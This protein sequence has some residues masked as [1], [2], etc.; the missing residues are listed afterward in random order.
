[1]IIMI[2]YSLVI[3]LNHLELDLNLFN[4]EF[5]IFYLYLSRSLGLA[6]IYF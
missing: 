4:I 6:Y 2:E 5:L 1:M 3:Y